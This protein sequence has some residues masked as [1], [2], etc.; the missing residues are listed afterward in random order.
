MNKWWKSPV[1]QGAENDYGQ[2]DYLIEELPEDYVKWNFS[3][4]LCKCD[5]CR[6]ERHLL[7]M[8][9]HYFYTLDGYDC[10]DYNECLICRLKSKIWSIKRKIRKKIEKEIDAIKC[11]RMCSQKD[12]KRCFRYY[13]RIL[14]KIEK[15]NC[16][17][18]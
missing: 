1:L 18:R 16:K 15:D 12:P 5:S 4:Y 8:S 7:L 11:A 9:A 3:R 14:K 13:Y 10:M 6:K 2:Y 17:R